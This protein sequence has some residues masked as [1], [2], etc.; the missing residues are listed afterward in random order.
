MIYR[1]YHKND[2]HAITSRLGGNLPVFG[3]KNSF[4]GKR[5]PKPFRLKLD[6]NSC[7]Y[8]SCSLHADFRNFKIFVFRHSLSHR[9]K[10]TIYPKM[11]FTIK[12]LKVRAFV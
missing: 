7:F 6:L 10:G 2:L 4:R 12:Y 8:A 11:F 1:E 3:N 5:G 9:R